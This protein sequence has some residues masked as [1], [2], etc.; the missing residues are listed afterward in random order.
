[1]CVPRKPHP[2]GNKYHSI[3]DADK[4]GSKPIMRR[5]KLVEGKDW[6]KRADGTW[7]FATQYDVRRLVTFKVL[8]FIT[9]QIVS[10]LYRFYFN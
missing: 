4:D 5:V 9:L 8:K 7:S 6:P 2:Q 10:L 3:A 1:M